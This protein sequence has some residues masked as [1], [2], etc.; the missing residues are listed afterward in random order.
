VSIAGDD[1]VQARSVV[2]TGAGAGIGRATA[3]ELAAQGWFVVGVEVD[4]EAAGELELALGARGAVAL[5]DVTDPAVLEAATRR[6]VEGAP[7]KG[8]VN[9]AGMTPRGTALH[10][11]DLDVARR[12]WA[13]NIEAT[14]VGC[15][16]AVNRFTDGGSIVNVS[17]IHSGQSY[18]S[19]PE[20]DMSKAA[21]EG[22]ARSIAVAY[23]RRGIRCNAVAPGAIDTGMFAEGIQN[24]GGSIAEANTPLGRIGQ[25]DEVAS[26]IAFLLGPRSSFITGQ[27]LRIDGGWSV[28]LAAQ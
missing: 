25:P 14:F 28:A 11:A 18:L 12:V 26:A 5:G 23:G 21:V 19:H 16:I 10:D 27:T 1:A 17:S 20:Y 15:K 8:W 13:L 7:L 24:A 22:L 4:P 9:N 2:V 3:L 6:A